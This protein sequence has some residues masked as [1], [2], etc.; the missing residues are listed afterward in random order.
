MHM[1]NNSLLVFVFLILPICEVTH[2]HAG[3]LYRY[4]LEYFR[5]TRPKTLIK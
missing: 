1:G 5:V 4:V 2:T 3:L